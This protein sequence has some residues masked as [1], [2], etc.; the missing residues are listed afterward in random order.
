MLDFNLQN[1][2]GQNKTLL[3][4]DDEGPAPKGNWIIFLWNSIDKTDEKIYS[5][6][7]LVE[8]YSDELK[9]A[10]ISWLYE[11]GEAEIS[12]G[13]LLDSFEIR[14]EF[15][16]WWMTLLAEK[17]VY[18]SPQISDAI[19]FLALETVLKQ[20]QPTAIILLSQRRDIANTFFAWC[21][22]LGI[23]FEWRK[24]E[25]SS[26]KSSLLRTFRFLV[27]YPGEAF[28]YLAWYIF[29]RWPRRDTISKK[30]Y[31][32]N[33]RVTFV[34][35]LIHL[36]QNA[37]SSGRFSS[38]YWTDLLKLLSGISVNWFHMFVPNA[39]TPS[40]PRSFELS[41][42]F[43][44]N[45]SGKED[46]RMLDSAL[47]ISL[48]IR[49]L[50]DY[51]YIAKKSYQTGN[52]KKHFRPAG[53]ALD[54]WPLFKADWYK[55][56]RG[57]TAMWNCILLNLFES[58]VSKL[59]K[60]KSGV[61]LL[62]NQAWEMAFNY[63]WRKYG[64]GTLLGV[65]HSTV[66]YWDTRYFYDQ[67]NFINRKPNDLPMP[68]QVL[69]NGP[70][71]L[72]FYL[73]G[74]YPPEQITEVEAL[75]YLYLDSLAGK[76][77]TTD[78][79]ERLNIL[80]CGDFLPES[81]R[82]MMQ[83]LESITENLP[84]FAAITVKPHPACE[85]LTSDYPSVEFSLT[86]SPLSELF[87]TSDVAFTSNSTSAA[88]DAYAS[89]IPVIQVWDGS[90]FNFSPLRGLKGVAYVSNPQE[91]AEALCSAGMPGSIVIEPYFHIDLK[92]KGWMKLLEIN[93]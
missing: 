2:S 18:K 87:S 92:L 23:K 82:Q 73:D 24:P 28:G 8:E 46:H 33:S 64:H 10:Y 29:Q 7:G 61:Y 55:S 70:V 68:D 74:G 49:I 91:L 86:N 38:N 20:L 66:R 34:D 76:H 69:V 1:T 21:K 45:S 40:P 35:Y 27:P 41:E 30:E 58:S 88:V 75:R 36:D 89:G 16:L 81:T 19:R 6:P 48:L 54:F 67:R 12:S 22:N 93:N 71:A 15:S 56:L 50:K 72:K 80:V 51:L 90:T 5:V 42:Q 39:S 9:A 26:R 25:H 63:A 60:Q 65:V 52:V 85:I 17:S 53:S 44:D 59:P 31:S 79:A 57:T 11:L 77:S 78:R 4:W 14:P 37:F 83:W 84:S 62:E 13:R 32:S 47:S 3:I 43:S